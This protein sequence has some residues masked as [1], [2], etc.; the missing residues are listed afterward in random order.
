[1]ARTDPEQRLRVLVVQLSASYA[2]TERHASE[3][4]TG[5]SAVHDVAMV[6]R[7]RP[8]EAARQ[9][10]YTALRGSVGRQVRLFLAGRAMPWLG[11][12]LAI[13]RFRPDV[14][15]A[16][17]ER[18]V[19]VA[20]ACA[21]FLGIPVIGTIHVRYTERDFAGCTA[22][23]ALTAAERRRA[24]AAGF[25]REI[26]VIEN[27][28]MPWPRP[29]A[30]RIAALRQELGLGH[31]FLFGCV[32]RLEPVK[33]MDLLIDAFAA[34]N[35]PQA[36]LVIIGDGSARPA[37]AA[38]V[39]R[40][41]LEGRVILAPFR[42]DVR[43]CYAA[44]GRFV[45]ASSF[46]PFALTLLEAAEQ[47]VPIISTPT[48]AAQAMARRMPITLVP[49]DD[50]DAL[51]AA[52]RAALGAPPHAPPLKGFAFADRLPQFE[53]LYRRVSAARGTCA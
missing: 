2:G 19:R 49:H 44:F 7:R 43:D 41:G 36:R 27:W 6:L 17:Y 25:A 8:P 32:G 46:D 53:A 16:H 34:A 30:A 29:T 31:A 1:M 11:V 14:I 48:E 21:R 20:C 9:D 15:H 39:A 5:L 52:M 40:L 13:L 23:V 50:V 22:L 33:R 18:S 4:A 47:L 12:L 10:Q 3:L 35:L 26:A 24:A 38:Q 42:A 51:A 28:V 37:L 45:T